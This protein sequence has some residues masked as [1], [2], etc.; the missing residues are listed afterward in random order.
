MNCKIS[1]KVDILGSRQRHR[2]P[3][4]LVA[5]SHDRG[6]GA[7]LH[8]GW[9]RATFEDAA[10]GLRLSLGDAPQ[11]WG[12]LALNFTALA[13]TLFSVCDVVIAGRSP[14][15]DSWDSV[16][17]TR[18]TQQSPKRNTDPALTQR[19]DSSTRES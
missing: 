1:N 9:L 14:S 13:F 7:R 17:V 2:D 6:H 12:L 19:R 16:D 5:G 15:S 8:H 10:R 4:L 3:A 18:V 11:V